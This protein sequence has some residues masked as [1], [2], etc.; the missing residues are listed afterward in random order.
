[1]KL[2]VIV[3]VLLMG[4]ATAAWAGRGDVDQISEASFAGKGF[5]PTN[6]DCK[7]LETK[8]AGLV[9]D[10]R[11]QVVRLAGWIADPKATG[12]APQL[13]DGKATR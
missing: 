11:P 13:G 4:M 8:T 12:E 2:F 3:S 9:T 1:M 5:D 6:P 7:C 10:N